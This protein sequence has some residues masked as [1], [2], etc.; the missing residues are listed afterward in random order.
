VLVFHFYSSFVGR[1]TLILRTGLGIVLAQKLLVYSMSNLNDGN[2]LEWS[3]L[4][5][6]VR[7]INSSVKWNVI[8]CSIRDSGCDVICLQETKKD[9]FDLAYLKNF[10]PLNLIHLLLFPWWGTREVQ[11]SS[12]KA[13][14]FQEI[15]SSKMITLSQ[16]NLLQIYRLAPGL[17]QTFMLLVLRKENSTSSIGCKIL[18]CLLT[19]FGSWLGTST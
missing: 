17:S 9:I 15:S 11:S 14:N 3:V 8:R 16:W 5:H 19:S 6:N 12:G 2:Y 13:Q 1:L 18:L 4:S 10:A 7:G